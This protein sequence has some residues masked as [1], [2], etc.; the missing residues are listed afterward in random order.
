MATSEELIK[1]FLHQDS[2]VDKVG[3]KV[4]VDV[5]EVENEDLQRGEVCRHE[6]K[7]VEM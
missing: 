7:G 5:L 1:D 3:D 6:E 4:K 2:S